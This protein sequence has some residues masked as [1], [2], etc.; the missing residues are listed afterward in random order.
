MK[1]KNLYSESLPI[2]KIKIYLLLATACASS[3][4]TLSLEAETAS[5]PGTQAAFEKL[6]ITN[7]KPEGWILE[8]L[9]RQRDGLTGNIEV[10]G[11]PFDTCLW[12]CEKMKGSTKA[13]WPYEQT[14][15]YLDGVQRLGLLLADESLVSKATENTDYVLGNISPSGRFGTK[16][17]DRWWR[18]P[19][20]SFVRLLMV[21]YDLYGDPQVLEAIH[22]HYLTFSAEDFMDDLELANVEQLCWLYERTGDSRMLEIAESAYRLF[23]SDLNNR[24]RGDKGVPSDMVFDS[25]RNPDHHGV[26]YLELLK[27]PALLYRC[28][29]NP[30]Y[31]FETINGLAKMEAHHMLAS[32]LPSTTEHFSGISE[33][34]G[35]ETCNT[36][37]LPY[38]YGIILRETGEAS[39]A[40]RIEKAVFNAAIGSVT[41]DFKAHQYFSAPNQFIATMNANPF[42][43]HPARMA[44]L[45][46]HDVECCTGNVNRFMPYYVEQMWLR[47]HDNGLAA[48]LYGPSSITTMVGESGTM[49][50]IHQATRYPFS[51]ELSFTIETE[52]SAHFPLYLRIPE[53]AEAPVISVNGQP[54]ALETVPGSFARLERTFANGDVVT[55]VLPMGVKTLEWPNNG[56][57]IERGPLVFSLPVAADVSVVPDYQKSTAEFPAFSMEPTGPWAFAASLEDGEIEVIASEFSGFPWEQEHTPVRLRVPVRKIE[58]WELQYLHDQGYDQ[59]MVLTPGFENEFAVADEVQYVELVPYGT[60]LLRLTVF[61]SLASSGEK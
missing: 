35:H 30:E 51:E 6:P 4:A 55:L 45:P 12:A 13:W 26:V 34:A 25:D 52:E 61:P 8:F 50:T 11:Y 44:F 39:L 46:G 42:G 15:Y 31:L 9:E 28:T 33:T 57:S 19:Y 36:A 27:I 1:M 48:A 29:G 56:L 7:I 58:N 32:G 14:A 54:E 40:D 22:N 23:K 16:L 18:W 38:T 47:S 24:N 10:A 49:V 37:V 59:D 53:W 43:H 2:M 5:V 21:Q 41:K 20:A 17:A 3:Q 60:T